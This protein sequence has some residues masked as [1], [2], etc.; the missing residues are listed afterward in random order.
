MDLTAYPLCKEADLSVYRPPLDF[1]INRIIKKECFSFT[2]Q[3]NGFWDAIIAAWIMAPS[4]REIRL[5]KEDYVRDLAVVMSKGKWDLEGLYYEP[6]FYAE[7][8]HLLRQLDQLDDSFFF[9]VSDTHFVPS[10]PPPYKKDDFMLPRKCIFKYL[11]TSSPLKYF[12]VRYRN[13]HEVIKLLL[14]EALPLFDGLIWKLYSYEDQI[15]KLF[16]AIQPHPIVLIGPAHYQDFTTLVPLPH[17]HF[18]PIHHSQA[19]KQRQEILQKIEQ[20]HKKL[21]S[22]THPPIYF[23]VAGSLSVWLVYHLHQRIEHKF[24]IDIGQAFNFLYPRKKGLLHRE[25]GYS[26]KADEGRKIYQYRSQRN[27]GSADF[28]S[29]MLIENHRVTF[30]VNLPFSQIWLEVLLATLKV[31][32]I[33]RKFLR[34]KHQ[35]F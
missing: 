17:Y 6:S 23:F 8:L 29:D 4:L 18:I 1:F 12:K 20:L 11:S 30:D 5:E 3:L 21:I 25:F 16:E 31:R 26:K 2:R 15:W 7:L 33:R 28:Q 32:P 19:S 13:R 22:N 35:L 9:G 27:Y 10:F 24:L 14:P 34:W